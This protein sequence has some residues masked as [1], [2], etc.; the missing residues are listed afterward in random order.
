MPGVEADNQ[1]GELAE[2][3]QSVTLTRILQLLQTID[4]KLD[5]MTNPEIGNAGTPDGGAGTPKRSD[6]PTPPDDPGPQTAD[7]IVEEESSK[8]KRGKGKR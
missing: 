1:L 5:A 4:W 6:L 7:E 2:R 3:Q 8:G